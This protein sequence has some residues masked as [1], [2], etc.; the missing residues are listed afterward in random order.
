MES[1]ANLGMELLPLLCA[2]HNVVEIVRVGVA[3]ADSA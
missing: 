3:H 2:E 1:L